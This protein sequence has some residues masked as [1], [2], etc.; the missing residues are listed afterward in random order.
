MTKTKKTR[1]SFCS[2]IS[3]FSAL[4]IGFS[5]VAP[6]YANAA[7]NTIYV[8]DIKIYECEDDDGSGEAAKRWFE[9]NGYVFT[10]IDLNR[11]TDTDECAYLGYQPTTNKDMAITDIRMMAMDTGYTI[12]NYKDMADYIASQKAGTAQT[13]QNAAVLFA[14]NYKAGSPKA[15]DAY[16]GLN[17]F[18]TGDANKTK[19]GD[20]IL[21]GKTSVRFFTEMIMKSSTGTL[22]AVHGFLNN[23]IAPYNNDLDEEGKAITTNWAEFTVKS[24]LWS[25][26]GSDDLST[27][28]RNELHKKYSDAARD[29]FRTIQ[30]FT[31]YYEDA[32]AK[33]HEK[34]A[35][36]GGDTMEKAAAEMENI[37]REDCG[38]LYLAAYD[39]LNA[40]EF[41]NGEKLG[42]LFITLGR[43]NSDNIDL[44]QLYP[45]VDRGDGKMPGGDCKYGRLHIRGTESCG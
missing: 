2:F 21:A 35:L 20:Y 11:G 27:D 8:S 45:V 40:Y 17:L 6:T 18:H 41:D 25:K 36:P 33:E 39:M 38:F 30:N 15:K 34:N 4:C 22:N 43:I 10:G 12:Y 5:T 3:V 1:R 29:L 24:G 19:L 31:T 7:D 44:T 16:E 26:I 14:E 13:L 9:A 32:K 28:E 42:D 37:E 23:G